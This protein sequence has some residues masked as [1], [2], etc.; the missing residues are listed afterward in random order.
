MKTV[1]ER[2]LSLFRAK[3]IEYSDFISL[4]IAGEFHKLLRVNIIL[5]SD[6]EKY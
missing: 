5:R 2:G 6:P 1:P 4:E 3:N